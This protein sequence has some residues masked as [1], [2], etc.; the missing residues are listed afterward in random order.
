MECFHS[1]TTEWLC[2]LSCNAQCVFIH[3]HEHFPLTS[4]LLLSSPSLSPP[5]SRPDRLTYNCNSLPI[6][7]GAFNQVSRCTWS[8]ELVGVENMGSVREVMQFIP[9]E[10]L[11]NVVN[12]CNWFIVFVEINGCRVT[13][14]SYLALRL[15][16]VRKYESDRRY[17]KRMLLYYSIAWSNGKLPAMCVQATVKA[18]WGFCALCSNTLC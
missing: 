7:Q 18:L 4:G 10:N 12:I 15:L 9:L 14:M 17:L 1:F 6:L 16:S 11:K 5:A 3:A 13:F 8:S 2:K